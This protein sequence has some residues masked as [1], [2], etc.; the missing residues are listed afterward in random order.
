M[1]DMC[2]NV[3]GGYAKKDLPPGR[4]TS[5]IPANYYISKDA[6]NDTEKTLHKALCNLQ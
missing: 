4:R 6:D 1:A 2:S 3:T 5:K